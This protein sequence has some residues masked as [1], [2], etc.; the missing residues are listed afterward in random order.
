MGRLGI[1]VSREREDK[2]PPYAQQVRR[3]N[4]PTPAGPVGLAG[5]GE[6]ATSG[7]GCRSQPP[8]T[9]A[10]TL[11]ELDCST[12]WFQPHLYANTAMPLG[13]THSSP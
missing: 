3:L 5:A 10:E 13:S 4:M 7:L 1:A 8:P 9:A 2:T 6:A 11:Q 12:A